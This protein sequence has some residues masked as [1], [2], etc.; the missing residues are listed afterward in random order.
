MRIEKKVFDQEKN[1]SLT[2]YIQEVGG[3]YRHVTKRPGILIIPGGAYQYCSDREGEP[4]AFEYL[5]AGFQAFILRYTVRTEWPEPLEDYEKAMEIIRNRADEWN[6]YVDKIAV[7]GFS[8]GGH[9]A[10]CAV[11]MARNKPRSEEHTSELQSH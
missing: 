8:A 4:V 3:E 6:L 2:A 1:T 11:T 5:K 10:A 9:L 7:I